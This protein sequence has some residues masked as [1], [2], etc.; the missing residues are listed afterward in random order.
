M[1]STVTVRGQ[2]V[3]PASIRKQFKIEP[4]DRLEWRVEGNVIKVYP[5][6][7]DPIVALEGK[8]KGTG[9]TKALIEGRQ[10]ERKLEAQKDV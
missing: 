4:K 6:P 8:L 7:A 9:I 10:K 1:K 2:T 5:I 3:I